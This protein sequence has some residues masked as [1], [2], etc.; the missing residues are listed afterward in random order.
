MRFSIVGCVCKKFA[1]INWYG[2]ARN[3]FCWDQ[4][5]PCRGAIVPNACN[6][7]STAPFLRAAGAVDPSQTQAAFTVSFAKHGDDYG[8]PRKLKAEDPQ[9]A[10][11]NSSGGPA[12]APPPPPCA[13]PCH[14]L[15]TGLDCQSQI[16]G[17]MGTQALNALSSS[18]LFVHEFLL[19][20]SL[21]SV[22]CNRISLPIRAI[23]VLVSAPPKQ[24]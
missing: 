24:N 18:S 17:S 2:T 10:K 23:G 11:W 1:K 6:V 21:E 13:A 15:L 4:A 16:E 20:P 8:E 5:V 12:P 3:F 7:Y 14:V 22:A 19:F 9:I